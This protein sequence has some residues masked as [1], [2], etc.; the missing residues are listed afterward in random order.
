MAT[1]RQVNIEVNRNQ[2][3]LCFEEDNGAQTREKYNF[4]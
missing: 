4:F 3:R 1:F 2:K